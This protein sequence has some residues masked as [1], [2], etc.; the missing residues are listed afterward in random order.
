MHHVKIFSVQKPEIMGSK[1]VITSQT[2]RKTGPRP[3]VLSKLFYLSYTTKCPVF[4]RIKHKRGDLKPNK[5]TR[6]LKIVK[7][8]C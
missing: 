2:S 5:I 3:G 1:L 4:G 7:F 6:L 8:D